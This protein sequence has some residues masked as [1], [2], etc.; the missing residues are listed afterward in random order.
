MF[1]YK[2]K[3]LQEKKKNITLFFS[4]VIS[5]SFLR[6]RTMSFLCCPTPIDCITMFIFIMMLLISIVNLGLNSYIVSQIDDH[7]TFDDLK[8]LFS[9]HFK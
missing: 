3:K 9:S 8:D 1:K 5:F 7:P 2:R 6:E 4:L